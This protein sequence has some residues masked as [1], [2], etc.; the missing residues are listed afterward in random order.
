MS[1]A[2]A[3]FRQS[4]EML[5]YYRRFLYLKVSNSHSIAYTLILSVKLKQVCVL[6]KEGLE[7]NNQKTHSSFRILERM[8]AQPLTTLSH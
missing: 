8:I 1:P 3:S 6:G 7:I 2:D 5:N 4:M